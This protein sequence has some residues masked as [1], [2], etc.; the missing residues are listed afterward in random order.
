[1]QQKRGKQRSLKQ[2]W[3]R[4]Q[5]STWENSKKSKTKKKTRI[6][7]LPGSNEIIYRWKRRT[8][9]DHEEESKEDGPATLENEGKH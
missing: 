9:E 7:P 1:M 6:P 4:T 5:Q 2:T 8:F 3:T